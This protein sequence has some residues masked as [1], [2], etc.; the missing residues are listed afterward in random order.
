MNRSLIA[1]I[2]VSLISSCVIMPHYETLTAKVSGQVVDDKGQPVAGAKVEYLYNSHRLL[3][4]SKTDHS[5]TFKAG[6]FRQWFYLIYLGSPGVYP[7]PYALDT[8][9]DFPDALK[10]RNHKT[11]AIYL[12]GSPYKHL[13]TLHPTHR[14]SFKLP[15]TMRWTGTNAFPTLILRSDMRDNFVPKSKINSF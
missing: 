12:L 15:P 2:L 6:P 10:I 4:I 13:S 14:K 9:R 3:G 5:G 1:V 8:K 11:S 7:F